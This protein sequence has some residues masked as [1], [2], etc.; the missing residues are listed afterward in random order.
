MFSLH[1][2]LGDIFTQDGTVAC[3]EPILKLRENGHYCAGKSQ[4]R[5]NLLGMG[6]SVVVN[7]IFYCMHKKISKE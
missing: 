3:F 4:I 7:I 1:L 5:G 6:D 2:H